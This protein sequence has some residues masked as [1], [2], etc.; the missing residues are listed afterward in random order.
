MTSSLVQEFEVTG[1]Q[2]KGPAAVSLSSLRLLQSRP[3]EAEAFA[4]MALADNPTDLLALTCLVGYQSAPDSGT[5]SACHLFKYFLAGCQVSCCSL[6]GRIAPLCTP[7]VM[8]EERTGQKA[9]IRSPFALG[10]QILN[11]CMQ[12]NAQAAAG[13]LEQARDLF[14]HALAVDGSSYHTQYNYGWEFCQ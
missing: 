1:L 10:H 4:E 6:L 8:T 5:I 12:G 7:Q 9:C 3:Q 14:A 2:G 13:N 11:A